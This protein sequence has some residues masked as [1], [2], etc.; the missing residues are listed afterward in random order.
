MPRLRL[1]ILPKTKK[2]YPAS[3]RVALEKI[4]AINFIGVAAWWPG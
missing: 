1:M 3:A 4:S 2:S